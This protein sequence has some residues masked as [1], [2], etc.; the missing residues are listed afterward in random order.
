[1]SFDVNR[2]KKT[3]NISPTDRLVSG[4]VKKVVSAPTRN[5]ADVAQYA[6]TS[7]LEAGVSS[8]GTS[9][10]TANRTDSVRSMSNASNRDIAGDTSLRATPDAITKNRHTASGSLNNHLLNTNPST[11]INAKRKNS[12]P[13]ILSITGQ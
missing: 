3:G 8:T 1:M 5:S 9:N 2:Y 6:A 13:Q 7:L 11:K 4:V 10:I 12:R